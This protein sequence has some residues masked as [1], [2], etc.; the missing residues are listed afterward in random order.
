MQDAIIYRPVNPNQVGDV[1][2]FVSRVFDEFVAPEFT[3]EGIQEFRRY[4]QP[5]A[6]LARL[7]STHFCLIGAVR[8]KTVGM[9]E[10][11]L[12]SDCA[13]TVQTG[14]IQGGTSYE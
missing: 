14:L 1:S 6:F 12:Y 7:Q 5:A 9:I 11:I 8:E 4:I 2:E 3:L 10:N 13:G